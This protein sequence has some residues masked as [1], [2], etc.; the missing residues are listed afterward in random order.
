MAGSV[1]ASND[2]RE[3]KG[4]LAIARRVIFT[5]A[6]IMFVQTIKNKVAEMFHQ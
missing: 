2:V 5:K 3:L 4:S 6:V 1:C